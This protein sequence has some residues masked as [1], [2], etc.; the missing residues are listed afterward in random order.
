MAKSFGLGKGGGMGLEALLGREANDDAQ[1]QSALDEIAVGL[2]DAN[3]WQPRTDFSQDDLEELASSI[4]SVGIIQPLTLRKIE[5]TGRYQIIAGE[6]R[7]RAAKMV[8]LATVPAYV[9]EVS[10]DKMLAVALIENIQRSNLNPIEEALSYQR[11]IDE[12]N[13]TQETLADQ[14]GKKRST[15]TNYLRLLKLPE[16]IRNGLR[17]KV[18]SM[19]H[20]RA[21]MGV[22][23]EET[24]LM[25][26]HETVE[27]GYSVRR[28][29]EMVREYNDPQ[30]GAQQEQPEGQTEAKKPKAKAQT[31]E[32]YRALGDHLSSYFKA[33]VKLACSADGKGK[34]T[35]PFTSSEDLERIMDI[36][37]SARQRPADA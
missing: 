18:I 37:D 36:L 14:V 27:Q 16:E 15:V 4:R 21:I 8:G 28:I 20:A 23:D 11:L 29:E 22:E 1:A 32:E 19:G 34:I 7:F 24:Q 6:R 25:L 35:I 10:D 12:C 26:F 17:D 9:R 5:E 13:L 31:P 2:I 33:N 30:A 3:P